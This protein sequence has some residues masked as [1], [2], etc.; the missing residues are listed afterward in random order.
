MG[1]VKQKSAFEHVQNAKIQIILSM[2][3]VS[4]RAHLFK[5]NDIVS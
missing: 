3:K 1:L 5:A 2:C 4:S